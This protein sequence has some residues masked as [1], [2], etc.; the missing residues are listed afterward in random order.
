MKE[1]EQSDVILYIFCS[2]D[3][4]VINAKPQNADS[5]PNIRN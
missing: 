4:G 1:G 5:D 3:L 2:I